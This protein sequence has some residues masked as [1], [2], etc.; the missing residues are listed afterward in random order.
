RP[1]MTALHCGDHAQ[2]SNALQLP[3]LNMPPD[4]FLKLTLGNL[5]AAQPFTDSVFAPPLIETLT[6]AGVTPAHLAAALR[7]HVLDLSK[8]DVRNNAPPF[9]S[10]T[11]TPGASTTYDITIPLGDEDETIH[12]SARKL[13][14]RVER[15][16]QQVGTRSRITSLAPWLVDEAKQQTVPSG[17]ATMTLKQD[18]ARL[19]AGKVWQSD[20]VSLKSR[21]GVSIPNQR[22]VM[23]F[24]A[25]TSDKHDARV[26]L[27]LMSSFT[28]A[29]ALPLSVSSSIG[30]ADYRDV[31]L[32]EKDGVRTMK[33]V[34]AID[35]VDRPNARTAQRLDKYFSTLVRYEL[36]G[37]QLV[38]LDL[39]VE[40]PMDWGDSTFIM[41]QSTL[42]LRPQ[43]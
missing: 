8:M 26:K 32:G 33:M 9:E 40:R 17:A 14:L 43:P 39:P 20:P 42:T 19:A 27:A 35:T 10:I 13:T 29:E 12:F 22:L 41:P 6:K 16:T 36:R 34:R 37:D 3:L 25:A 18:A 21:D 15:T 23:E 2:V 4:F 7:R 24:A 5:L 38:L 28:A 1:L 31:H 30:D 11:R